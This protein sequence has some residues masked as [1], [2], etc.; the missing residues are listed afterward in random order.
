MKI[1]NERG[2]ALVLTLF[3]TMALS[4]LAASLLFLSQTE[5]YASANYRLMS[6]AR[7][8][9]ESGVHR[10]INH[11][12]NS[13]TPPGGAGDPLG[14]YDLTVSPVT[15]NG[16]PVVL[17]ANSAVASNYPVS[18]VRS[19][20]QTAAQGSL[21]A[22]STT[23][24]YAPYA[25]LLSMRQV[26]T[27]GGTAVTVQTWQITSTGTISAARTAQVEV[28]SVL[29]RHIT[30]AYSYAAFATSGNCG[31]LGFSGGV[32]TD[33]YD[34]QN[35]QMQDGHV[36]TQLSGGNVGTNGNLTV[37]GS[38]T[39][40]NGTL[41]TPRTGVGN[42]NNGAPDALTESGDATVTGGIIQLPQSVSLAAPSPP[43]PLPPTDNINI[44][45]GDTCGPISG[46]SNGLPSGLQ[47][48]PGTYG[49]ISLTGGATLHLGAGTYAINSISL[50]G[51]S[52]LIIDSG[53]VILNVAGQ[54]QNTP[55]DLTGGTVVN[56]SLDPSNLQ[57]PYAGTGT[58]KVS[59]GS[60]NAAL[61]YAP[62]ASTQLSGGSD[63]FGSI[64]AS[65]L[66][67]SGG[68]AIHYDRRLANEFFTVG[69]YMLGS[70]T[71]KK[72]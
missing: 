50:A 19:A 39:T 32:V 56:A 57:I 33:S 23:V 8:G 4:L 71:W 28:S 34:S 70:F 63:F 58:I 45:G 66:S 5:T 59:G 46:C 38:G 9:A 10:A 67:V 25:T 64:I 69:N 7:Y 29:E 60:Q 22:G 16:H 44:S 30:P 17:S 36:V 11:L 42:C 21:A 2:M 37:S 51:N 13:Y 31:A 3:M 54:N 53:P 15:Y 43:S 49:N 55:V 48:A 1:S 35:I 40:V 24:Q 27:Y 18:E 62:S 14:N 52:T 72:Y 65:T 47:L 26:S 61:V 68:T 6:Q 41:S 12:I 20:F